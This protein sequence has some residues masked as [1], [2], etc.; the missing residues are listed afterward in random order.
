[1]TRWIMNRHQEYMLF[2]QVA[3]GATMAVAMALLAG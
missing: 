2:C 1:M 3:V